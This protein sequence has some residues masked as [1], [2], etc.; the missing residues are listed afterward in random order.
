MRCFAPKDMSP[1]Y[2]GRRDVRM[3]MIRH[4]S[5]KLVP[6]WITKYM[7]SEDVLEKTRDGIQ[8]LRRK[9]LVKK[10]NC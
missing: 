6:N 8:N 3:L 4:I 1:M 7:L 2:F 5:I 9:Q 10:L